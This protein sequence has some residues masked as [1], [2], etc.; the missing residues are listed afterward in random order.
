MKGVDTTGPQK[1]IGELA[2]ENH[3]I[4]VVGLNFSSE[5][6]GMLNSLSLDLSNHRWS[7]PPIAGL[8]HQV[9]NYTRVEDRKTAQDIV[10]AMA[11]VSYLGRY[12]PRKQKKTLKIKKNNYR[13][14]KART[15]IAR[16]R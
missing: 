9:K 7:Y 10:M 2:F 3:G 16:R 4:E 13:S 15:N 5:K 8:L 6:Q 12:V 1:A 14:R 11:M